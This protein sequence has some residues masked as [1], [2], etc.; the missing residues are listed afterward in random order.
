MQ[1]VYAIDLVLHKAA[2][3]AQPLLGCRLSFA[4]GRLG[5]AVKHLPLAGRP[6]RPG[7]QP[8]PEFAPRLGI[9]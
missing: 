6:P 4:A 8:H 1:A 9:L 3:G 2:M 5:H 7:E